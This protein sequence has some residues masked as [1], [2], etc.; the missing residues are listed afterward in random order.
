MYVIRRAAFFFLARIA[1]CSRFQTNRLP[2]PSESH[3]P[4]EYKRQ[5]EKPAILSGDI[6]EVCELRGITLCRPKTTHTTCG[7]CQKPVRIAVFAA[8]AMASL[9]DSLLKIVAQDTANASPERQPKPKSSERAKRSFL[10]CRSFP[11]GD[12]RYKTDPRL[13]VSTSVVAAQVGDKK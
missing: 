2:A 1:K 11:H 4:I 7:S 10:T 8:S 6:P 12:G 9:A 3:Y 13:A 5:S